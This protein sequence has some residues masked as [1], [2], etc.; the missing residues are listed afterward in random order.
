MIKTVVAARYV[1]LV[2]CLVCRC[3]RRTHFLLN[4]A[5]HCG[6]SCGLSPVCIRV[7]TLRLA[8]EAHCRLHTLQV[9]T[10]WPWVVLKSATSPYEVSIASCLR[11]CT[12]ISLDW[13][14]KSKPLSRRFQSSCVMPCYCAF[15]F[16]W[17]YIPL[18]CVIIYECWR[19]YT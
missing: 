9:Y 14:R 8:D 4:A 10:F 6:H 17:N 19:R 15:C 13:K 11:L 1:I 2:L 12:V 18:N 7:C 16:R 5:P 3:L